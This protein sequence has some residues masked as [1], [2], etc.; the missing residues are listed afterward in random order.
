LRLR[1]RSAYLVVVKTDSQQ[2]VDIAHKAL[3]RS[4]PT[5]FA[6]A[7]VVQAS[8]NVDRFCGISSSS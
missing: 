7:Q 6:G 1:A 8:K 3:S 4:N 2:L 5:L